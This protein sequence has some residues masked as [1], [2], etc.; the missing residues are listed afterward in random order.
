[1]ARKTTKADSA[2]HELT[3]PELA[4]PELAKPKPAKPKP[5]KPKPATSAARSAKV[6]KA[7]AKPSL[8]KAIGRPRKQAAEP[9]T[10]SAMIASLYESA[11]EIVADRLQPSIDQIKALAR[12]VIGQAE[13]K[14]RKVQAKAAKA[15]KSKRVKAP[16]TTSKAAKP[17]KSK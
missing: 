5:A 1:M 16:A 14:A 12:A 9:E 15:A 4:K 3:K 11:T 8:K 2:T 13:K 7:K 17:K 10:L 6:T